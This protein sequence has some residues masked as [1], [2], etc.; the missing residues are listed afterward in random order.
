MLKNK[1]RVWAIVA[2]VLLVVFIIATSLL[3]IQNNDLKNKNDKLSANLTSAQSAKSKS[4]KDLV[5]IKT[6]VSQKLNVLKILL[7]DNTTQDDQF[8]AYA[9]IQSI[10]N[11]TLTADW[12]AM[13]NNE[14]S[15]N[16]NNGQ[17]MTQDIISA[18]L[19]EL[20]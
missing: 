17:K 18:S 3:Y 20:K 10:N 6:S 9:L 8:K 5:D 11:S 15:N 13:Q 16:D 14:P 2:S 12:K 1:I 19:K 4:D 7:S